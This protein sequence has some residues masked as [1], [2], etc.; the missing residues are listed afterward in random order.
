MLKYI[1][2]RILIAIPVLIGITVIDFL[3]MTMVGSPLELLQ[4]PRVSEA[5]IETKRIA[6][7]LNKPVYVQYWIWLTNLLQGNMGYSMKS[8]QPVSQMIKAYIGPTLLLMS[9][10]LFVSMLI[11]VPAGIYSAVHKYTPQDY[12]VVTLSFLGSSVPSFFLALVLIYLFTVRL[13]W[14][15]SSGMYTLG[16]QKSA[17]DV[18]R[19]MIM[20]VI[21]LAT[22]MAG[23][24]I[25]YI[26]SA[27]LEILR[28]D[29][30]RTARAKGIGR[31]LVI[32]KHALRNALIPVITVFGMHI[33]I[34]FGGAIIIEQVFSWP[35]LGMMTMS[36]IISRDYP[37]IMGVCLM[38]A[39]VVL[40][41]NLLTDII[42]ALVDPTITY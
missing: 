36:A 35:G 23:T 27:M 19:H 8:F 25:R 40:V 28:M 34:L 10:S 30:L 31:F 41:A 18:L 1:I 39:I 26:R 5:A 24:N 16:A 38:S 22:S 3:I 14:L 17:I 9:V 33:P 12:T 37:V 7:G 2:K 4:G 11:A 13:G 20:P 21:V 42:Y 29:Y 15:P 6:L 32:N